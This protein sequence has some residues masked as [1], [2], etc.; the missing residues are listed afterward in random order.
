MLLKIAAKTDKSLLTSASVNQLWGAVWAT[1][2]ACSG[3]GAGASGTAAAAEVGE[4]TC[5]RLQA[6]LFCLAPAN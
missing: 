1:G 6:W 4:V 2:H 3:A 5:T